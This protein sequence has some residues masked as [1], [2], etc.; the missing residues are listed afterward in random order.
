MFIIVALTQSCTNDENEVPVKNKYS[1]K[2]E[3]KTKSQYSNNLNLISKLE[4]LNANID[5]KKENKSV[6]SGLYNFTIETDYALY[7]EFDNGTF[8]Y[9]FPI[10]RETK[11]PTNQ[12]ESFVL[13][14][15]T[16]GNLRAQY[17]KYELTPEELS[18]I[19]SQPIP[20][21]KITIIDIEDDDLIL[22]V[23]QNKSGGESDGNNDG[24]S[25][26]VVGGYWAENWLNFY[27]TRVW[28]EVYGWVYH[29]NEDIPNISNIDPCWNCDGTGG[30]Y[31][32]NIDDYN[33]SSGGTGVNINSFTA[34]TPSFVSIA[35]LESL[36]NNGISVNSTTI[37]WI[38][39]TQNNANQAQQ[40]LDYINA[41]NNSAEAQNF[42]NQALEV[43]MDGGNINL[44]EPLII[45]PSHP[46]N[47]NDLNTF[48][49]CFN[50]NE[51]GNITI[52]VAEPNP[53]TGDT[54]DSFYVGHTFISL[55]QN[56]KIRVFGFYP[57]SDWISPINT[58]SNSI[59]GNDGVEN[60][61]FTAYNTPQKM[62]HWLS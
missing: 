55:S 11:T 20:S 39:Q 60:E 41:N 33:E 27:R 32:D 45:N 43:L 1:F 3:L 24:W 17:F 14:S 49:N 53:G 4:K 13:T 61:T 28:V 56:N 12:I 7:V 9:T 2:T 34:T 30:N 51:S 38:N 31:D 16:N 46:I 15:S 23:N 40:I 62:H 5:K 57:Q 19:G 50:T 44:N 35:L 54:H 18:N 48:F 58:S 22:E 8:S 29:P 59:I 36:A 10:S 26:E 21:D 52:Y 25:W 6:Y 42:G 47:N 37:A